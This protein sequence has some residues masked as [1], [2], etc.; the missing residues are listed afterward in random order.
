M[1]SGVDLHSAANEAIQMCNYWIGGS[2]IVRFQ[3]GTYKAVP[4]SYVTHITVPHTL[5]YSLVSLYE[6]YGPETDHHEYV[7]YAELLIGIDRICKSIQ[8][9]EV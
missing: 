4:I 7:T 2:A 9:L 6:L 8:N 3:D 5:V 1:S